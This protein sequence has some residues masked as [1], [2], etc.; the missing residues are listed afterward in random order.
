MS[1]DVPF[2]V[3]RTGDD[4]L[5]QKSFLHVCPL[6][7]PVTWFCIIFLKLNER[8]DKSLESECP[9]ATQSTVIAVNNHFL[10]NI[11]ICTIT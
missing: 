8:E 1:V 5:A 2:Y 7:F 3:E 11:W 10:L 6:R 9:E 4:I